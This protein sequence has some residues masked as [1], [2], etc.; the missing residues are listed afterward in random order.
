M[1]KTEVIHFL[2]KIKAY[3]QHFV[4][5]DYVVNEWADKLK[6]YDINDVYRK[7]DEHL[8]G[9]YKNDVP[10]LHFITRYL[11]TPQEK[12]NSKVYKVKCDLCGKS[13]NYEQ[14]KLHISRHNSVSYI[15]SREKYIGRIFNEEKLFEMNQEDF[16]NLYNKFIE[17]L[18]DAM[19]DKKEKHRLKNII[20]SSAGMPVEFELEEVY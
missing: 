14:L 4:I 13:M 16:D 12:T 17:Q 6:K 19:P 20:L 1:T 3:Y 10:K 15:K 8:Q 5:E 18:Y 11:K 9:E 2:E 7:F